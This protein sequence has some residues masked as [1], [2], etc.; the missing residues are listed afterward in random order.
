MARDNGT[1]K[2]GMPKPFTT[3]NLFAAPEAAISFY[4][5]Q[6]GNTLCPSVREFLACVAEYD[7]EAVFNVQPGFATNYVT[8]ARRG[9]R[10]GWFYAKPDGIAFRVGHWRNVEALL[11]TFDELEPEPGLAQGSHRAASFVWVTAE[12]ATCG[13]AQLALR[14]SAAW[15]VPNATSDRCQ[16]TR[17]E[18]LAA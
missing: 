1:G 9:D 14:M 15:A 16:P 12:H 4:E 17:P 13:G 10:A 8:A 6:T 3:K 2:P 11:D 7:P 18:R 5:T